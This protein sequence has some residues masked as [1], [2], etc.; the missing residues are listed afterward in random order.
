MVAAARPE[1]ARMHGDR[2]DR[3]AEIA[4]HA[5]DAVFIGRFGTR[6]AARAFRIDDQLAAGRSSSLRPLQHLDH[7]LAARAAI[8][9]DHALLAGVP[10]EQRDPHQFALEDVDRIASARAAA[11]SVS[12][13][14]W[15][16]G[17]KM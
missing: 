12:Q 16:F 2:H 8:D 13:K 5:G 15:C 9:R 4:V 17:A 10:A 3:H 6:R 11:R 1:Q 14:D 7:D